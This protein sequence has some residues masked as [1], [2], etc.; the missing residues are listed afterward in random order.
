MGRQIRKYHPW[1]GLVYSHLGHNYYIFRQY[2]WQSCNLNLI[3]N[4]L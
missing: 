4:I 3:N 1:Q 2:K